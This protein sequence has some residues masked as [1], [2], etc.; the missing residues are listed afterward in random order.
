L[1]KSPDSSELHTLAADIP[2][3]TVDIAALR[4]ARERTVSAEE[5]LAFLASLGDAPRDV[6]AARPLLRGEAFVLP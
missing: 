1:T 6:L 5:C 4:N 2:T 3:T